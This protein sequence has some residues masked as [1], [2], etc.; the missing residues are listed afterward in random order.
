MKIYLPE[1]QIIELLT[2]KG[3]KKPSELDKLEIL[4]SLSLLMTEVY[5][6][7]WKPKELQVAK[8]EWKVLEAAAQIWEKEKKNLSICF[9]L[10]L[11]WLKVIN[12][13]SVFSCE[14]NFEKIAVIVLNPQTSRIKLFS[15]GILFD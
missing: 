13:L 14:G 10:G 15:E 4:K 2:G 6:Y 7:R 1:T 9:T 12:T 5:F 11:C 3:I 8:H